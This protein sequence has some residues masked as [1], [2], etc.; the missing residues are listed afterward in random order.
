[1]TTTYYGHYYKVTRRPG[2]CI[3]TGTIITFPPC[4]YYRRPLTSYNN[5]ESVPNINNLQI[6]ES[7]ALD[8]DYGNPGIFT[9]V[10]AHATIQW[11]SLRS[12]MKI[13][14]DLSAYEFSWNGTVHE[15]G[16][17]I[18]MDDLLEKAL[19]FLHKVVTVLNK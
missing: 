15:S 19:E 10:N 13:Q 16:K 18:D 8:G 4:Y 17:P 7:L 2:R 3:D 1:M 6:F 12:F 9:V 11:P 5:Y 14:N